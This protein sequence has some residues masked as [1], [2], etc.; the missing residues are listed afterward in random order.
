MNEQTIERQRKFK[1]LCIDYKGGVCESCGYNHYYGALE[2]H[3]HD[4]NEK[5]FTIAHA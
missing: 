3:H 1:Q 2:F 4:L 5:D